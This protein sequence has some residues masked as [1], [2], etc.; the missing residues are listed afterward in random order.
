MAGDPVAEKSGF[1]RM[2]MSSH[3]DTL[4]AYA[5]WYGK[6]TEPIS[7][8]EM[9]AIDTK[10]MTLSC[11]LKDG[12][13]KEVRVP[14][15]P[16]M[17][18]YDDVKPRLLEMKALAQE[19]LGMIKTPQITTFRLPPAALWVPLVIYP[20]LIY[21][22]YA[23]VNNP[24]LVYLPARFLAKYV[25]S[26]VGY[27]AFWSVNVAH[28]FEALYTWSLCWKHQSGFFVTTV[29]VVSTLACGLHIWKDLRKRIQDARIESVM[30]IE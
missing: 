29:Y 10:S 7:S 28:F 13:T 5:K 18:G 6:V 22:A 15:D 30:K 27:W 25:G 12:K 4:V 8:A 24:A 1:L 23:P 19:G 3:P 9:S 17:T 11:K 21:F 26:S 20:I 2:Y 14:I 16:P